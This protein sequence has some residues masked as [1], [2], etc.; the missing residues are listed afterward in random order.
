M[1]NE[2]KKKKWGRGNKENKIVSRN[3]AAK[4]EYTPALAPVGIH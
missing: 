1:R 3:A 4:W 2:K